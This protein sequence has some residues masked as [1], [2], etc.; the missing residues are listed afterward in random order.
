[1][2]TLISCATG[3]LTDAATWKL[4]DPLTVL[5]STAGSTTNSGTSYAPAGGTT[6]PQFSATAITIDGISLKVSSKGSTGTFSAQLYN[7]T[8]GAAVAGTEVTVNVADLPS[9]G[10]VF[11]KFAAPVTLINANNYIIQMKSSSAAQVILQR[12]GTTANYYRNLRTTTTQAP[13]AGDQLVVIGE[14]TGA[15]TGN[16]FTVTWN[17]SAAVT[18]GSLSYI[19]SLFIA[20]GG[21]LTMKPS[22]VGTTY[23]MEVDGNIRIQGGV[24]NSGV[25]AG[26]GAVARPVYAP[27]RGR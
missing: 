2:A 25:S 22:E 14:L 3:D 15:G 20:I 21:T 13:A 11:L 10:W 26:G 6:G 24:F 23:H 5:D 7:N 8:A 12:S 9:R 19:E 27:R 17:Q 18:Y 1:M 16:Q 4:V